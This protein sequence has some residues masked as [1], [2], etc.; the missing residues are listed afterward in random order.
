[1]NLQ[2]DRWCDEAGGNIVVSYESKKPKVAPTKIDVTNPFW[3][4]FKSCI[5]D[6]L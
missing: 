6:D 3:V 1:M 2:I 4:A 5:C